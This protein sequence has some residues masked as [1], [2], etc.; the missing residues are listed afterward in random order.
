MT[1]LVLGLEQ[2]IASKLLEPGALRTLVSTRS[3]PA[4]LPQGQT[5]PAV[6]WQKIPGGLYIT[7]HG[8][9]DGLLM[10]HYQFDA[11]AST[12]VS[13]VTVGDALMALL[14]AWKKRAIINDSWD[15]FEAETGLY[16]ISVDVH[17][18]NVL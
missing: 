1:D 6:T 8:G 18:W 2:D 17:I 15:F 12:K 4:P 14:G 13:A 16:R 5:M 9:L 10:G 7:T 11:W 3:T